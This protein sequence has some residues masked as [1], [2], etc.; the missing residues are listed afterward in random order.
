VMISYTDTQK[1]IYDT[2]DR[3]YPLNSFPESIYVI[4]KIPEWKNQNK[5]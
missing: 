4:Y 3:T 1:N 5:K 2:N